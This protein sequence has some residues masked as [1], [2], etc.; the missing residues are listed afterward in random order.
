MAA[1]Q[2]ANVPGMG[3]SPDPLT[4][5]TSGLAT[6]KGQGRPRAAQRWRS[7]AHRVLLGFNSIGDY[8]I[9]FMARGDPGLLSAG[10]A[11]QNGRL[12]LNKSTK[13]LNI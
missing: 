7:A 6:T 9:G 1:Y 12:R 2:R 13:D 11:L 5:T 8:T 3:T 4:V 10:E